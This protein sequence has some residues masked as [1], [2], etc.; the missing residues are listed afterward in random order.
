[1]NIDI[2]AVVRTL[3]EEHNIERCLQSLDFCREIVVIDSGS[4]DATVKL[5]RKYT[6]RVLFHEM[7]GFGPQLIWGTEQCKHDWVL[8]LDADEA[9]SPELKSQVLNLE[10]G[11][12]TAGYYFNRITNYLGRWI[13][14]SGWYPQYILRLFNKKCGGCSNAAVHERIIVNGKTEKLSGDILHYS[15]R[16]LSHHLAKIDEY[17]SRMAEERYRSGRRFS[18]LKAGFAPPGE[19]LKKYFLKRGFLDGFPGLAV[20][21]TSA[22]YTFLKQA[23]LYEYQKLMMRDE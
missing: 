8:F 4:S 20:A 21:M 18:L 19:F 2:S 11:D 13:R 1:M 17:T 9:V 16:N 10:P 23:K 5:A 14:H 3:N 15:Y 7:K 22:N 6:D 12:E